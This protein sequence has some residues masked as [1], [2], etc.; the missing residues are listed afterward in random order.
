MSLFLKIFELCFGYT[1]L[2]KYSY[3]CNK[4]S[5]IAS[6]K[7]ILSY[8]LLSTIAFVSHAGTVSIKDWSGSGFALKDN[9]IVTNYHVVEGATHIYIKGI[10]GD[11]SKEYAATVV[12]IDKE[13]DLAIVQIDDE[14]FTGFGTIPYSIQPDIAEVGE[15]VFVL[16]YPMT[17]IMGEEIK[18]TTGVINSYS[19]YKGDNSTYQIS[20]PIQPGNSGGPLFNKE[21]EVIG[22]VNA[23]LLIAENAGYAIKS[24]YLSKYIEPTP[25]AD[26][27]TPPCLTWLME[28]KD[29]IKNMVTKG[30]DISKMSLVEQVKTI[31]NYVFI[32][33]CCVKPKLYHIR[34]TTT[35]GKRLTLNN[36]QGVALH[37]FENGVGV[38]YLLKPIMPESLFMGCQYLKSITIGDEVRNISRYAFARC[39]N[40]SNIHIPNS[41]IS[42]Q[43]HAFDSCCNIESITIPNSVSTIEF[44]AFNECSNLTHVIL[45]ENLSK[46]ENGLFDGCTKLTNIRLPNSIT[47]IGAY[48]FSDCD[49]ITNIT[50]PDKVTSIEEGAFRYCYNI[51]ELAIPNGVTFIGASA[52]YGCRNLSSVT[53][54]KNISKIGYEAFR[55]CHALT[56]I[57]C[58]SSTPPRLDWP[59]FGGNTYR[60]YVY[61]P[62]SSVKAYQSNYDWS[63]YD[64]INIQPFDFD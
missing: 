5:P 10:N 52:F 64:I 3:L 14:N 26:S 54:G 32:V 60:L 11:F 1:L 40:L 21:G 19:G 6:M 48:A 7:K 25:K 35:N 2:R 15:D 41:V 45:P 31:K 8:L 46:I 42:I 29:K 59:S 38:V 4:I 37:T 9:L 57:Y 22:I 16:G 23:K 43:Y 33:K 12:D 47:S 36:T 28:L 53:M 63:R 34:Y 27:H 62:S 24:L 56:R 44:W 13:N 61:V 55:N 50:I 49:S 18:L 20:A 39:Y 30:T 58:K 51:T 17:T